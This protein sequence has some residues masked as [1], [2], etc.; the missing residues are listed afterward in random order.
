MSRADRW[1]AKV[2]EECA[3]DPALRADLREALA[4][5]EAERFQA[6]RSG[7]KPPPPRPYRKRPKPKL[8]SRW[9]VM[10]DPH[11]DPDHDNR[12]FEWAGRW[13]ADRQPEV[14]V[15]IGDLWD[16]ASLNG[17]EKRGSRSFEG[18]RYYLDVEAGL[19]ALDRMFLA[20]DGFRPKRMVF[21][22][23]NHESRLGRFLEEEP[24]FAE[25][26]GY[27]DLRLEEYG[28]EV[29]PSGEVLTI[30]GVSMSHYFDRTNGYGAKWTPQA[31][32]NSTNTEGSWIFGHTHRLGYLQTP[33]A[34]IVDA[35]CF[36]DFEMHWLPKSHQRKWW[37]GLVELNDV[38]EGRFSLS[39]LGI[40]EVE[41]RYS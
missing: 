26:V 17:Y 29:V 18:R 19:D 1:I 5:Q 38:A 37:R 13:V 11:A 39:T 14:F 16:F 34:S 8:G 41:A 3:Q 23:G 31:C 10:G 32:L 7:E 40:G 36:F 9:C 30:D 24:R 21:T 12:R 27:H 15:M 2:Q 20:M 28:F 33:Q 25:T 22:M 6:R 35:G 4:R